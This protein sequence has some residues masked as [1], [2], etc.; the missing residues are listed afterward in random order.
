[1]VKRTD[2]ERIAELQ[3]KKAKI[4]EQEKKLKAKIAKEERNKRTKRLVE[5]GAVIESALGMQFDTKEERE[6][7]LHV[8]TCARESQNGNSFS[9]ANFIVQNYQSYNVTNEN[10]H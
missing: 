1:M 4:I 9:L 2:Q 7:L 6:K 3:Q 10:E 5:T 8:L